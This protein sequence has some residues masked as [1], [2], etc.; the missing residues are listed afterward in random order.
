MHSFSASQPELKPDEL[1][2]VFNALAN[3]TRR[4]ILVQLG[5]GPASVGEIGRAFEMSQPGVSK[6]L[7]V[8]EQAGLITREI[9]QQRRPATLAPDQLALAVSWLKQFA[10]FWEESLDQLD[11]LLQ[12]LDLETKDLET[13]D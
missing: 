2:A 13:K 10:Q 12:T 1:D 4:D 5:G 8:L 3:A 9:D 6:H 7:K 11:A